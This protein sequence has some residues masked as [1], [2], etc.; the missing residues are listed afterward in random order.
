MQDDDL[1]YK[2]RSVAD[3]LILLALCCP[4]LFFLATIG[5]ICVLLGLFKC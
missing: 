4:V 3:N 1:N 2:N 5:V